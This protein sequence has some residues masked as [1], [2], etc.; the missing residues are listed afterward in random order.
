M[1]LRRLEPFSDPDDMPPAEPPP[2]LKALS[3]READTKAGRDEPQSP[4]AFRALESVLR[5]K[6]SL[7]RNTVFKL[8]AL[9]LAELVMYAAGI[10]LTVLAAVAIG[11][12]GDGFATWALSRRSSGRA[13]KQLAEATQS[14]ASNDAVAFSD[15][16]SALARGNLTGHLDMRA[17]PLPTSSDPELERVLEG[18]S[19]VIKRLGEGAREFNKVTDEPCQRLFYVGPDGYLQGHVMGKAMGEGLNGRGQVLVMTG[20]FSQLGLELRRVGFESHLRE[21]FPDVEVVD[22]VENNYDQAQGYALTRAY[23]KRYP[24]LRGIYSTEASGISGAAR[25]V[26]EAGKAGQIKIFC[27]DLVDETMP[28]V[29][30]GVINGTVGQDPFAQGHDPVIHLFNHLVT[31]WTPPSPMLLTEMDLVTSD[32]YAQFWQAGK[33]IIESETVAQRR[34]RPIRPAMKRLRIVV[35][36]V[37]DNPFWNPSRPALSQPPPSSGPST[38]TSSGSWRSPRRTSASRSGDRRWMP[39]WPS[40]S[41]PSPRPSTTRRLSPTSTAPWPT[42]FLWQRST[43]RLRACAH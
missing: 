20:Q 2:G 39:S 25:A 24:M 1:Q 3:D 40:G 4:P 38:P 18:M 33:G 32:N 5:L 10:G 37:E 12:A 22:D 30:Q 42:G 23:M 27:H 14:L 16:L 31:G 6:S 8:G 36:G 41:A 43:R 21:K 26:A 13:M 19:A 17:L 34:A 15:T 9:V 35:L 7:R 29:V 11:A 28:Y